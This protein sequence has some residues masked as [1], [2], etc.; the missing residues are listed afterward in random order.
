MGIGAFPPSYGYVLVDLLRKFFL[1]HVWAT[2]WSV[3]VLHPFVDEGNSVVHFSPWGQFQ[4][5]RT[6]Y[7]LVFLEPF[8]PHVLEPFFFAAFLGG[9]SVRLPDLFILDDVGHDLNDKFIDSCYF[10]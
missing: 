4:W 1:H 2:W 10:L 9:F 8:V 5:G 3:L 7:V 6:Y